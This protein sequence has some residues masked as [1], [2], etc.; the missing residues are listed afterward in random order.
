[1]KAEIYIR[2]RWDVDTARI[3]MQ[4]NSDKIDKQYLERVFILFS[5]YDRNFKNA[6]AMSD[7]VKPGNMMYF[8]DSATFYIFKGKICY[9]LGDTARARAYFDSVRLILEPKIIQ[10]YA[11]QHSRY[12]GIEHSR[13]GLAYAFLGR[14]KEAI[15][16]GEQGKNMMPVSKSFMSGIERLIYLAEIYMVTGEK[17]KAVNVLDYLMSVPG[18]MSLAT[19]KYS[20]DWDPLREHP[21][22]QELINKYEQID[23]I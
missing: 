23:T 8:D 3:I 16:M 6:L 19:L 21:G 14:T 11:T 18:D 2:W 20:P 22:F 9:K 10:E 7:N 4:E 5:F 15:Q 1:M 13:L 12:A 17:E